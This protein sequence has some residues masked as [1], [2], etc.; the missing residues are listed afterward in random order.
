MRTGYIV[1]TIMI[2]SGC[3]TNH[4]SVPQSHHVESIGEQ[5][6]YDIGYAAITA[7]LGYNPPGRD[8]WKFWEVYVRQ[9]DGRPVWWV[10]VDLAPAGGGDHAYAAVDARTGD[11]VHAVAG[12]HLR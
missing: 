3:A 12:R 6:A 7:K 5:Q 4:M 10:S 8:K 11:V 2:A 1:A 9:M